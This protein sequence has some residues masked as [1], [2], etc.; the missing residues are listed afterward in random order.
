[1]F[2]HFTR[3]TRDPSAERKNGKGFANVKKY[4]VEETGEA[5]KEEKLGH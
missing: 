1:M 5:K 3:R 4:S 2:G